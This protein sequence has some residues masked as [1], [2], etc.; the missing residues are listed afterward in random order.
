MHRLYCRLNL[1]LAKFQALELEFLHWCG[2]C[3][4]I[5]AGVS[6][7]VGYDPKRWYLLRPNMWWYWI[8]C[9]T[10]SPQRPYWLILKYYF[11]RKYRQ[12]C[13]QEYFVFWL[14]DSLY[15]KFVSVNHTVS[16]VSVFRGRFKSTST[17]SDTYLNFLL[18]NPIFFHI[19]FNRLHDVENPGENNIF[20]HM[21]G[22]VGRVYMIYTHGKL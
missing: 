20:I 2:A 12:T 4:K 17:H 21:Y 15:D 9:G 7:L 19:S 13:Y 14:K 1:G 6:N 5:R 18:R 11:D 10:C 16:D 3:C 22:L 8:S